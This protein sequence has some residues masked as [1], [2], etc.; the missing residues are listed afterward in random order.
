MQNDSV[1]NNPLRFSGMNVNHATLPTVRRIL[2]E[3]LAEFDPAYWLELREASP[4]V[5]AAAL[6][7]YALVRKRLS[8]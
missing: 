7:T 5:Q 1:M 4:S 6:R 8:P 3:S 2:C